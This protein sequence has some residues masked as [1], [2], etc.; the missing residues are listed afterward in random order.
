MGMFNESRNPV[1][2]EKVFKKAKTKVETLDGHLIEEREE[3]EI[4]TMGGAVDKTLILFAL[5]SITTIFSYQNASMPLLLVGAI[6]GLIAVLVATFKPHT[7]PIVAPIYALLEGLFVGTISYMFAAESDGIIF[8]AVTLTLGTCL[9]MLMVYKSGLIKI[10]QKFRMGVIM[11]TGAIFLVYLFSFVG[12][13]VGFNVPYIHDSGPLGIGISVVIIGV[14]ALNLLLDFDMFEKGA[15]QGA[16]KYMEWFCG[17]A[18]MVTIVWLYIEF[19]RLLAKLQ[20]D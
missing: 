16:P 20:R 3:Y 15:E 8:Q 19:L 12:S 4:M 5:L 11:A 17:L 6:G 9:M 13:F 18:L 14:A 1:L 10:T 7:S 2:N